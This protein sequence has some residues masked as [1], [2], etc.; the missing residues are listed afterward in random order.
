MPSEEGVGT[1]G[2]GGGGGDDGEARATKGRKEARSG[3]NALT[4]DAPPCP[5]SL[6][7]SASLQT[8]CE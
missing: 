5:P 4:T 2:G 1:D 8:T 6:A 3:S 7:A